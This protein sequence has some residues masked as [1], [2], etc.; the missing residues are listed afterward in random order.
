MKKIA[1][2]F[3]VLLMTILLL[4]EPFT[5]VAVQ[6]AEFDPGLELHSEAVALINLD[7]GVTVYTKNGNARM[8]PAS[9]TKI[10]VAMMLLEHVQDDISRLHNINITVR[11]YI[12]DELYGTNSSLSGLVKNE[13]LTA[14]QMI[15]CLMIPSGND[16]AMA[17]AD[18]LG[19]GD[20]SAFV[21]QMNA[22]VAELGCT[23]THFSNPHGLHDEDHYT[24]A[25]DMAKI[26][27]HILSSSY[28]DKF[29]S[30][31]T[32]KAY[33]LGPSNVRKKN[34]TVYSTNNMH[35]SSSKYYYRYTQGIK[36][37][38]TPEAGYCLATT[39][40]NPNVNYRYL[41][42]TFG[43]PMTDDAGKRLDNGAMIDHKALYQ[44]A[45]SKLVYKN[46]LAGKTAVKQIGLNFCWDTD[47]ML[48]VPE[49]DF[50]ALV[51]SHIT[52]DS[53][54]LIPNDD[55]PE[56]V[57]APVQAGQVLGT[58]NVTYAGMVLGTVNLVADTGAEASQLLLLKAQAIQMLQSVWLKVGLIA[59]AVL[60]AAYIIISIVHNARR[61]KRR[62]NA[63]RG[64]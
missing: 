12:I 31:C 28:A 6:A 2:F 1:K 35:L 3:V 5:G 48:L 22:R 64:R 55:V 61:K 60:L 18:Y 34:M 8:E 44:W 27:Q 13:T 56:S 17:I 24:S 16:A 40:F 47:S 62:R 43:A 10:V 4:T 54:V 11:P 25:N 49:S 26:I 15:H 21:D 45:F 63:N 7:T 32:T 52:P 37:G 33:V 38:S 57:D 59:V 50:S 30:I 14:E 42:V 36:T 20:I 29:M 51:P 39:A 53:I 23:N 46:L 19:N 41:C 58:A 9:V